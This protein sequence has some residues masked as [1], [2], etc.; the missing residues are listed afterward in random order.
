ML[1]QI[2]ILGSG[3]HRIL[4][5]QRIAPHPIPKFWFN[6]TLE[7]MLKLVEP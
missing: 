1:S 7:R 3:A 4:Q 2:D 5:P 6:Q